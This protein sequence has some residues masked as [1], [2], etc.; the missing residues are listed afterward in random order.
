LIFIQKRSTADRITGI[1]VMI[2]ENIFAEN[3]RLDIPNAAAVCAEKESRLRFSKKIHLFA[4]MGSNS[5][6][7][8]PKR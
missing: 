5:S 2:L 8:G 6:Q 1:N 4:K 3:R 7:Y